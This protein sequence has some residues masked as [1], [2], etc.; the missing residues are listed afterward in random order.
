MSPRR[1]RHR[2]SHLVQL[3]QRTPT[4]TPHPCSSVTGDEP[5]P[6]LAGCRRRASAPAHRRRASVPAHGVLRTCAAPP[7]QG[8][9]HCL[10]AAIAGPAPPCHPPPDRRGA[11]PGSSHRSVMVAA[12]SR[13]AEDAGERMIQQQSKLPTLLLHPLA[14]S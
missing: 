5:P 13:D 9:R 1:P 8:M 11:A 7:A 3:L 10:P 12:S 6:Q 14:Y 2:R 4:W